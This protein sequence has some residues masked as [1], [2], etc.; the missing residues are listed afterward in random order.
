MTQA[1]AS[2]I[3]QREFYSIRLP[4]LYES[5]KAANGGNSLS[6]YMDVSVC[7]D[8]L[9]DNVY[10]CVEEADNLCSRLREMGGTIT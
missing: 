5:A 3:R 2:N 8:H 6:I 4:R 10:G 1:S 9:E 7:L